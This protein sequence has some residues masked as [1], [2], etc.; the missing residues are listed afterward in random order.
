M[1]VCNNF[2]WRFH[3]FTVLS[4]LAVAIVSPSG[5]NATPL[6]QFSWPVRVCNNFPWR[7]HNFT[8]L[9]ALA[10]AIVSPSGLNATASTQFSCA[11]KCLSWWYFCSLI[12][13][14]TCLRTFITLILFSGRGWNIRLGR[15]SCFTALKA[16][17]KPS[18]SL[19]ESDN[20]LA[21]ILLRTA[22]AS[23]NLRFARQTITPA[24]TAPINDSANSVKLMRSNFCAFRW[25]FSNVWFA[26]AIACFAN[27]WEAVKKR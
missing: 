27:S 12:M 16:C 9:S 7:F 6:T 18:K 4:A 15:G 10:V 13:F 3:N 23:A 5:L 19:P 21:I 1:R 17:S 11:S 22:S 2:P 8:V 25:A 24:I 20:N 14:T 26:S